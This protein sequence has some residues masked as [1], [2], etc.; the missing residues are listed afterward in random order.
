[1]L[2]PSEDLPSEG[3]HL[4]T[5]ERADEGYTNA[6]DPA[7]RI[8][9]RVVAPVEE[10]GGEVYIVQAMTAAAVRFARQLFISIGYQ[11]SQLGPNVSIDPED[12][13]GWSFGVLLQHKQNAKGYTNAWVIDNCPVSDDRVSHLVADSEPPEAPDSAADVPAPSPPT[14]PQAADPFEEGTEPSGS[15]E[16]LRRRPRPKPLPR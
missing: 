9:A 6:G 7:I 5:I 13:V 8:W 1:M 2:F 15:A 4:V 12:L 16:P 11:P 14:V 3:W 10:A